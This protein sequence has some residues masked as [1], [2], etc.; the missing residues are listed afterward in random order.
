[1]DYPFYNK[2]IMM[3]WSFCLIISFGTY[4]LS[5][6]FFKIAP[7]IIFFALPEYFFVRVL[8]DIGGKLIKEEK[9]IL[10]KVWVVMV[11]SFL[12]ITFFYILGSVQLSRITKDP[13]YMHYLSYRN[14]FKM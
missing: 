13:S 9:S 3:I 8:L 7:I 2:K 14:W 1:M 5:N 12:F 6:W 4:F 11:F 10:K